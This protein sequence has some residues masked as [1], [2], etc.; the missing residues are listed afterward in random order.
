MFDI[1]RLIRKNTRDLTP[2]SSAR[3]EYSGE[4]AV[5]LDA[6]EN[7]FDTGANRYPDPLQWK[8][9][10]R[11]GQIKNVHYE[12]IFL[13]NGSDEPIDLLMR[14][15]CNPG[16]DNIVVMK[17][18]YGMYR[19]SADINDV[20]CREVM[21]TR[22]FQLDLDSMLGRVDKQTKLIFLCSPNNPTSNS[23]I[24]EDILY[25]IESFEGLVILDEAY[26]DFS[27][28]QSLLPELVNY[29]NL[30]VLQTLSKA[31]GMAGIRLGMA[32]ASRE[33]VQILTKI[34]YPYNINKLTQ[35][36]ALDRLNRENEKNQ[37]V[38]N[39]L[40]QR[41]R[42]NRELKNFKMVKD[43]LISDANFLMVRF[44]KP[45]ELFRYLIARKIILRDRSRVPL[46]EGC[47]RITVGTEQENSMLMTALKEYEDQGN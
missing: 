7:P 4:D 19:V 22:E 12:N 37:A 25:L 32:F 29:P 43:I 20:E 33:I 40:R 34:K 42:L 18:S 30:V 28:G 36:F 31:W 46:C 11:I 2:Y 14:A 26:I 8:L 38:E 24:R 27:T 45:L 17:P 15:F 41:E 3:D 23:L 10:V 47:L 21:L 5:F 35:Q 6:N 39:I 9:K 1:Y 13:G 16:R 44:E